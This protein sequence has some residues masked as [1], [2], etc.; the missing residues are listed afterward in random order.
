MGFRFW[1]IG[2]GGERIGFVFGKEIW[3]KIQA[4][5]CQFVFQG[6][7]YFSIAF[8]DKE[9]GFISFSFFV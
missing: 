3:T 2:F 5:Y 8:D 7:G 6:A 4:F 1:V 9:A